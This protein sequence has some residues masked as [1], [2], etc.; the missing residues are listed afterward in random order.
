MQSSRR[1]ELPSKSEQRNSCGNPAEPRNKP[2][3]VSGRL[4][5]RA[6]VVLRRW[7]LFKPSQ[8]AVCNRMAWPILG[9]LSKL[10]FDIKI[11]HV[12]PHLICASDSP[13]RIVSGRFVLSSLDLSRLSA[14]D[15]CF[16]TVPT[17][18]PV[19]AA[20]S[21]TECPCRYRRTVTVRSCSGSVETA[22]NKASWPGSTE[23]S[24]AAVRDS[25]SCSER[26]VDVLFLH[27]KASRRA[28]LETHDPKESG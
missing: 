19:N 18:L 15:S 9:E 20:M 14:R 21:A 12:K 10:F 25:T 1:S 7:L 5:G 13:S 8:Y 28:M 4:A 2:A 27:R 3:S 22:A 16:V 26:T 6:F 23:L 11:R 17:G 24:A